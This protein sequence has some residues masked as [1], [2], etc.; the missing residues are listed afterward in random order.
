MDQALDHFKSADPVMYVLLKN[1][2]ESSTKPLKMPNKSASGKYIEEI[3]SSIVSQQLSVKAAATIWQRFVDLVKNPG[4][5]KSILQHD[6]DQL[7]SVGLSGQKI[8]YITG[9]ADDII[10]GRVTIDH[11]DELSDQE[12]IDELVKFK[13]VGVWT[14]EM[15]LIFCLARKDVF[16]V[17]DL[18]LRN[19]VTRAYYLPSTSSEEI[20]RISSAWSPYRSYASLA[21]WHSLDNKPN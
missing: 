1:A 5:P 11:L 13:G 8:K 10:S 20:L 9:I 2:I 12:V 3:F 16:S 21:L 6:F 14:A 18:G 17:L 15:F 19:A 7:R 4:D